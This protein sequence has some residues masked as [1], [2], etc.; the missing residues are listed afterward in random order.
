[1]SAKPNSSNSDSSQRSWHRHPL[2]ISAFSIIFGSIGVGI[3]QNSFAEKKAVREKRYAVAEKLM[4]YVGQASTTLRLYD[5][6]ASEAIAA[7]EFPMKPERFRPVQ[8]SLN[9]TFE[10]QNQLE[11]ELAVFFSS[12]KPLTAFQR[13]TTTYEHAI[14]SAETARKSGK[15]ASHSFASY[16]TDLGDKASYCICAM[17]DDLPIADI[18]AGRCATLKPGRQ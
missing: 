2:A 14:D 15:Y 17:K 9:S 18:G 5:L 6:A 16:T 3:L 13:F 1:M 11:V 7:R 10:L 8:Q 4:L 12:E